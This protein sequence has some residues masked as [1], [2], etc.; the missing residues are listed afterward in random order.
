MLVD[1]IDFVEFDRQW[2]GLFDDGCDYELVVNG[3]TAER[4]S[5]TLRTKYTET[6]FTQWG[7]E[8][9]GF[10]LSWAHNMPDRE[11]TLSFRKKPESLPEGWRRVEGSVEWRR[12]VQTIRI[13]IPT[14]LWMYAT[15]RG[16]T[17]YLGSVRLVRKTAEGLT[18]AQAAKQ[19][20]EATVVALHEFIREITHKRED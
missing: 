10:F 8:G 11:V 1:K 4:K 9:S 3:F 16:I 5:K 17:S 6:A 20:E 2:R 15:E 12:N 19:C 18:P 7:K 14:S 13:D